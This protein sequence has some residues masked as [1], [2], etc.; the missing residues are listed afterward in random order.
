[1]RDKQIKWLLS[2]ALL[3]LTFLT[4]YMFL[5]LNVLWNPLI[6]VVKAIF[7]PFLIAAFIT[8]LLHPLIEKLHESGVQRPLAIFIIYLL[9][10][11][12]IGYGFYRGI[13]VL[14]EQLKDLSNNI[15]YIAKTY[16][17]WLSFIHNQTDHWPDGIHERIDGFFHD[18]EIWMNH[19]ID[20]VLRS[21]G[22]LVD[23][24]LVLAII[25]FLVFYM[26]KDFEVLKKSAW[27]LTPKKWRKQGQQFMKDLDHSLGSYIRGQFFVCVLIGFLAFISLWIFQV[28]Y[29][30]ILGLIIGIT[31]IIPYFGPLIGAVPALIIASTMSPRIVLMVVIIILT[32]QFIEG[33]ILG[34]LIVGK[35]LHMHPIVIMLALLAGGKL[36][37]ILGMIL[38]VPVVVI[39]KVLI[40]HLA[41]LKWQH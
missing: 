31:N 13:P 39:M 7:G 15:P 10:F 4:I 41:Q 8:Y 34:P 19:A 26:L 23:Y 14:I 35:S 38:A 5:K 17:S 33:N 37:G 25:P 29:P 1:M 9:F 22:K 30:L 16:N 36:A 21:I 2:I 11:G 24:I 27:Y 40:V 18:I 6:T 3:L 28:R 20:K 12:A 32:L